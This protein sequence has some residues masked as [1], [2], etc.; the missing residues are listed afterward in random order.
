MAQKKT[1]KE[2]LK[3][4]DPFKY[5]R[6]AYWGLQTAEW[7]CIGAPI[8]AVF[9]AKW[10]EYF[11]FTNNQGESIRLTIGCVIALICAAIFVYKKARHQ[12]KVEKKVTMLTY[13]LGVG[14]AFAIAFFFKAIIDD[15][16]LILGCELAGAAAAYG[17]DFQTQ[18]VKKKQEIYE[19]ARAKADAD[20]AV[21]RQRAYEEEKRRR[22]VE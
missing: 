13:V 6:N 18:R 2:P 10:N 11:D 22:A 21:Q 9:G 1:K 7:A 3:K 16:V 8:I 15:L 20:D 4:R 14:A 19:Y 12:E 5:Y 17:I